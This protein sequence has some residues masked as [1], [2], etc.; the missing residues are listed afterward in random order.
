VVIDRFMS[1]SF[2][3]ALPEETKRELEARIRAL[4]NI[5]PELRQET[6]AFPYQTEAWLSERVS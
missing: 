6:I 2:I 4:Q 3:A 1:V 5:Y